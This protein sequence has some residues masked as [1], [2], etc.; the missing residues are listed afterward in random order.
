MALTA[1]KAELLERVAAAL[2]LSGWQ[3]LWLN[4]DHPGKARLIRGSQALDAWIYIWN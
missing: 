2:H 4:E 1:E 3:L